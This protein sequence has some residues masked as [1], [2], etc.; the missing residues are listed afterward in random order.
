MSL[1]HHIIR[2]QFEFKIDFDLKFS[3]IPPSGPVNICWS[4]VDISNAKTCHHWWS[5]Y[6]VPLDMYGQTSREKE[7]KKTGG[8]QIWLVGSYLGLWHRASGMSCQV[9]VLPWHHASVVLFHIIEFHPLHKINNSATSNKSQNE[10]IAATFRRVTQLTDII[11]EFCCVSKKSNFGQVHQSHWPQT[12]RECTI[13]KEIFGSAHR[14]ELNLEGGGDKQSDWSENTLE[15]SQWK[16]IEVKTKWRK[17]VQ[18]RLL[19]FHS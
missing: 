17:A 10:P 16:A 11:N 2:P 12:K 3:F 8:N 5:G 6:R 19:S 9:R 14:T 4:V 15:K 13:V 7:K 18:I 1:S